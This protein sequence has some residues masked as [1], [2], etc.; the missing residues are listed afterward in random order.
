MWHGKFLALQFCSVGKGILTKKSLIQRLT[1]LMVSLAV[2]ASI[3]LVPQ[4]AQASPSGTDWVSV[5]A[6]Y[7]H[8][9]GIDTVKRISCWGRNDDGQLG[10]GSTTTTEFPTLISSAGDLAGLQF[11]QVSASYTHTCALT[12]DGVAY[13]WGK[14]DQGQLGVTGITESKI[15][16]PVDATGYLAG[17][18][19]T[20]IDTGFNHTCVLADGQMYCWG[21]NDDGQLGDGTLDPVIRDFP[22]P[23][24]TSGVLA[25]KLIQEIGVGSIATCALDTDGLV[26]CWGYGREGQMGDGLGNNLNPFPVAVSTAGVLAGKFISHISV[27]DSSVCAIDSDGELYCWGLNSSGQLGDATFVSARE[28]VLVNKSGIIT[29]QL[30]STISTGGTF[31]CTVTV[32]GRLSCWGDENQGQLGNGKAAT[33]SSTY[34]SN[35]P[36]NVLQTGSAVMNGV[37]ITQVS[38][39]FAHTCVLSTAGRAYCWGL[40]DYGQLGNGVS[41]FTATGTPVL[42]KDPPPLP[43]TLTDSDAVTAS[44]T[45]GNVFTSTKVAEKASG[46]SLRFAIKSGSLPPGLVINK[47]TGFITGTPTKDGTFNCEITVSNAAGTQT[48]SQTIV[49]SKTSVATPKPTA[50]TIVVKDSISTSGKAKGMTLKPTGKIYARVS[51]QFAGPISGKAVVLY[52]DQTSGKIVTFRCAFKRFGVLKVNPKAKI[53]GAVFPER[54]IISSNWCQLPLAARQ[55]LAKEKIQISLDLHFDRRWPTTYKAVTPSGRKLIPWNYSVTVT[56]GNGAI[57]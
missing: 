43:P 33:S 28:P 45:V 56:A 54:E 42:V 12:V 38:S 2:L 18:V 7:Q 24:D 27:G 6:G 4:D 11:T 57:I 16:I 15:P 10:N 23:I 46:Y 44:G 52:R 35:I 53:I 19:I 14:N 47:L 55:T 30:P 20:Q 17:L 9:C 25:G 40:N 22:A 26:A 37:K 51:T 29:S 32:D 41:T 36:V 39:G 34:K 21:G 49:I 3:T 48:L 1:M 8:S 13:C 5:A 50:S 31:G